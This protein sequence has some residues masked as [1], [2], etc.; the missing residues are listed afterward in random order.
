MSTTYWPPEGTPEFVS[1]DDERTWTPLCDCGD[2]MTPG[3][4]PNGVWVCYGDAHPIHRSWC[5]APEDWPDYYED[6][7]D[8]EGGPVC[9][10]CGDD[11]T[12]DEVILSLAHDRTILCVKHTSHDDEGSAS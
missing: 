8:D 3:S 1:H 11:V 5:I 2:E 4:A 6:G 12:E 9:E 10:D 7:E